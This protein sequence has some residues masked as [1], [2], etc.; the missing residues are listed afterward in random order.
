SVTF[1]PGAVSSSTRR[2]TALQGYWS[3]DVCSS[4][5]TVRL[6]DQYGN[7]LTSGG[8][9]VALFTDHGS[10]GSVTD[11]GNG[12]YSATLSDTVT[13][14]DTVTGKVNTHAITDDADRKS[15]R[16]NSSDLA[17]TNAASRTT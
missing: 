2:N 1:T 17:T 6:K 11:N 3:S 4:A 9:T 5:L 10:L 7:N 13:E 8:D 16:L 15:T 14:T 12:T